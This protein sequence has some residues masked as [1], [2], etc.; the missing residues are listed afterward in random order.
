MNRLIEFTGP[1]MSEQQSDGH[2]APRCAWQ[3]FDATVPHDE[4]AVPPAE[5]GSGQDAAVSWPLPPSPSSVRLARRLTGEQLEHW[6]LGDQRDVAELLVSELVTNAVRHAEGRIDLTVRV[7]DGAVRFEVHDEDA[8]SAP[9]IRRV[10]K[11]EE[12]GRGLHLVALLSSGWG[13]TRTEHGKV[14]WFEL[15]TSGP[16]Q[17]DNADM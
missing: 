15:R 3:T 4:L 14:V 6:R 9:R 7:R 13:T 1:L 11:G 5:S 16:S 17:D 10:G 12:G 8:A 2:R